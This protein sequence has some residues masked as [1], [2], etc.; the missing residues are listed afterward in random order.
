MAA[1]PEQPSALLV[2]DNPAALRALA[3]L[4]EMLGWDTAKTGNSDE[5][6]A[7]LKERDFDLAII[8]LNMPVMNG[9]ELCRLISRQT[10]EKTPIIFILSGYVDAKTHAEALISGARVV[11]H[12]PMGLDDIRGVLQKFG[13]PCK[14]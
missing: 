12:K 10:R 1:L 14:I 11:L 8:D 6:L 13:L 4:L 2:D 3:M 9:I 7:W 5:A